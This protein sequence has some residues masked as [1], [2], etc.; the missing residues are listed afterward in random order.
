VPESY[1]WFLALR[2]LVTRAIHFVALL[3]T[4]LAVWA[5]IVVISVFSGMVKEIHDHVRASSAEILI[6]DIDPPVSYEEI[7]KLVEADPSVA[8]TAPRLS[9]VGV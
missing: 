7:K 9:L 4:A 6:Q 2:Y 5:L 1:T 3:G 8:S